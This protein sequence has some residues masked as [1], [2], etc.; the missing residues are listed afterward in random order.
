MKA[1]QAWQHTAG[2]ACSFGLRR[3]ELAGIMDTATAPASGQNFVTG[4][5][6]LMTIVSPRVLSVSLIFS[7]CLS[8]FFNKKTRQSFPVQ[9]VVG[10]HSSN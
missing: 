8:F 6:G 10:R 3:V 7:L 1:Q 5:N 9:L 4:R 2:S